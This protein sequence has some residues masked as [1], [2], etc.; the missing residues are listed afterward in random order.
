MQLKL[1]AR[2][3]LAIVSF[4]SALPALAASTTYLQPRPKDYA[5]E[6]VAGISQ[7]ELTR[8]WWQW[9]SSFEY[10]ESPI[11]DPT[12]ERCAAGQEGPVWFLA[13]TYGSAPARRTC[14]V[15]AG[16][17]LFFPLIN[18]VVMPR[19]CNCSSCE[20]AT[21]MAKSITNSPMGLF[22]ELDGKSMDKLEEHRVASPPGCF[23]MAGRLANGPKI[24]PSASDGYWMHLPPL[25]KGTHKLRF[26]GSLSSLRQELN[27]TLIV[28]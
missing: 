8:R 4:A 18:Y 9:A 27:Y 6:Q 24:E 17:H 7:S 3:A 10:A 11:S 15:P 28:E 13:G 12:G 23:N 22:V 14:H 5:N 25:E 21:E 1:I 26:G 16:K 19:N 2:Y 20:V